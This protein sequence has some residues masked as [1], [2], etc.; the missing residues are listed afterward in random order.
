MIFV[1]SLVSTNVVFYD[2]KGNYQGLKVSKFHL[3]K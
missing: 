3:V 1:W 2:E